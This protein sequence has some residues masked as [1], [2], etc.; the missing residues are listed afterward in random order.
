MFAIR[1]RLRIVDVCVLIGALVIVSPTTSSAV[2]SSI[3]LTSKCQ[4]SEPLHYSSNREVI[5]TF[6]S[7]LRSASVE[8]I[9]DA[10]YVTWNFAQNVIPPP[11]SSNLDLTVTFDRH[12][13]TLGKSPFDFALGASD[14]G[15]DSGLPGWRVR[16][17]SLTHTTNFPA[18]V[19][20]WS[21]HV[22]AFF[23]RSWLPDR[24]RPLYWFASVIYT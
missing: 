17:L 23:A 7:P 14:G 8:E 4:T 15:Q 22:Q 20:V 12:R 11:G 3:A 9:S 10:V 2:T 6:S 13:G 1:K 18:G 16:V 5:D 21:N 24:T 19:S